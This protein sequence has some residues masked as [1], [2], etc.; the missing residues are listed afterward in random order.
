M[1]KTAS[2]TGLWT[3]TATWGGAAVPIDGD[4][5]TINTGITV[6]FDDDH[7]PNGK[8]FTTGLNSL[9]ITGTLRF[10]TTNM[11]GSGLVATAM[12]A[13]DVYMLIM[14][15]GSSITGAG[16]LYVGDAATTGNY[17][18]RSA[19][20]AA[21]SPCVPTVTIKLAGAASS[22]RPHNGTTDGYQQR[23]QH[24]RHGQLSRDN[25][26]RLR[27]QHPVKQLSMWR[28]VTA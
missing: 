21:G 11:N 14:K 8:N 3:N 28:L 7:G 4:D 15:S 6:Y 12:N 10:P 18:A 20:A 22:R 17:I 1:T 16:A 13:L 2:V 5:V 27:A 25:P 24:I 23:P 9:V 19:A 26:Q